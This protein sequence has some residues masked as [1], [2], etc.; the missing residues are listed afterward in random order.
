MP[1]RNQLQLLYTAALRS[2]NLLEPW[3]FLTYLRCHN[4]GAVRDEKQ[5]DQLVSFVQII[6]HIQES[7]NI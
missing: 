4:Y 1:G 5:P 3:P 2:W 7:W 6:S